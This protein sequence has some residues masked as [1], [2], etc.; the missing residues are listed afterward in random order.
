MVPIC[1]TYCYVYLVGGIVFAIGLYFAFKQGYV[2]FSG[3]RLRNLLICLAVFGVFALLQG[4]LQHAPMDEAQPAPYRGGAEHV[5]DEQ[6]VR[7]QP[8]DYAIMIGYFVA[9][10]AVGTWFGRRQRTTKDFFFGGQRFAWWLIA[11]SLIATTV[12]SY[13]FVKYS[14]VGYTYGLASSQSYLNDWI[15]FPLL[16]FGWLPILYFSRVTSVPEYF[17]RRFGPAVRLWATF[18]ILIYLVGYVGV[19][20]FTMGKVLNTLVGWDI[21]WAALV[22]ATISASYVTVGGQTSVIMTDLL[23]G[24]MLLLAGLLVLALGIHYLGGF[25]TFWANLPRETRLAFANFNQKPDF[26][27]VGIFWQD[28]VANSAMFYF[29][30]QGIAMRFL[31]SRSL[32]DSRKAVLVMMLV[33]M[34]VAACVVASGGWIARALV[35]AGALPDD[36]RP[37]Q[38]F[39]IASELLCRPGVFGLILAAL[40]AALMSTVDT[41][42]TAVSAIVVNDLYRPY[43]HPKA[44]EKQL[45]RTARISAVSVTVLG[46]LLVPVFM[47]FR[48]IYEAHGAF[49]AAVTPPLVVVLLLSVFCRRFTRAAALATL[50][51][52]M[53][54]ITFSL[55]YPQVIK[56]FSFGVPMQDP[57]G[58]GILWGMRQFQFMRAFYG[59]SAS[60]LIAVVVMWLSRPEP[61]A[62]QRGLVWGTIAEAIRHYKG[63]PGSEQKHRASTGS[64]RV[65][66]EELPLVGEGQLPVVHL[67]GQLAE[68]IEAAPGDLVYI[69]DTRHWL[70]GLRS[71]QAIVQRIDTAAEGRV[72]WLGPQTHET[73]VA[74]SRRNRPFRIQRLY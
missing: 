32:A 30:N 14:R 23:Q 45:L 55:F 9:I 58:A 2:G 21:R 56:P 35:N 16:V 31:A 18:Y 74:R 66:E 61:L 19:N 17:G 20:L 36:I 26:P 65:M 3:T 40:T 44:N 12:G 29:L 57:E 73:V 46:V 60:A 72:L 59:L 43:I 48:S 1:Y 6:S 54:A 34:P 71:A 15:W 5:L 27:S 37:D 28:A 52:G 42:I 69:C 70:G 50:V 51:G 25:E 8:I 22:V 4:W 39:F 41:L 33:L 53:V 47:R 24:V 64:V 38:A 67:S 13:S 68:S 11:F 10:L 63:S 62:R 7:G 49:T